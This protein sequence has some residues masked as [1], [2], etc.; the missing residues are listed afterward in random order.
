[1]P[2]FTFLFLN[3]VK[4]SG[5]KACANIILFLESHF[6]IPFKH[7]RSFYC[8]A[9]PPFI[10]SVPMLMEIFGSV[11]CYYKHVFFEYLYDFNRSEIALSKDICI[12]NF[13][14]NG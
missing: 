9:M 4:K 8:L 14:I 3:L 12:L 10:Q 5:H 1:M 13:H 6:L 2:G 11:F 7:C